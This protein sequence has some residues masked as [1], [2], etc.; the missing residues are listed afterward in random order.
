VPPPPERVVRPWAEDVALLALLQDLLAGAR[1]NSPEYLRK[2]LETLAE[3]LGFEHGIDVVDYDGSNRGLFE[4]IP[5]E[6]ARRTVRPALVRD[7]E[8]LRPGEAREPVTIT[9]EGVSR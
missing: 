9:S 4:V 8:L 2:R 5:A 6:G 3:D 1:R 7:G